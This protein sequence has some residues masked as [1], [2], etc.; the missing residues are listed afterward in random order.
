MASANEEFI[1]NFDKGNNL[2]AS[3]F[4]NHVFNFEEENKAILFNAFQYL[5]MALIPVVL[6]L[7][8]IKNYIPEDDN[9][10]QTMEITFEIILQLFIIVFFIYILDKIIRYFPTFSK[11]NYSEMNIINIILPTLIILLTLQTKLG[12]K[13]NIIYDRLTD[14]MG[15]NTETSNTKY[16][17][18][19]N[20][21]VANGNNHINTPQIHQV[22]R[23]DQLDN[24]MI[25]PPPG[26]MNNPNISLIDNLPNF[27][28]NN[29][30]NNIPNGVMQ[31]VFNDNEPMAA[32]DMLS[33]NMFA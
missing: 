14:M 13:I 10:K 6:I 16:V 15:N 27:V 30:V 23:A 17:G 1:T 2:S 29:P 25:P 20:Y 3:G 21:A 8:F 12:A 11:I 28:N 4:F 18:K 32:N 7:K 22:S 19:T 31:N 26:Q 24:T 5:F 33:G 9:E